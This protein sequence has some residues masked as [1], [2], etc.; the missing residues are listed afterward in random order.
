LPSDGIGPEA[1]TESVQTLEVLAKLPGRF[2]LETQHVDW[3]TERYLRQ[4]VLMS[5]DGLA[6]LEQGGFDGILLGT[7]GEPG[8]RGYSEGDR[9][10]R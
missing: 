6:V 7:V 9:G 8:N 5:K 4:G 3:G 2:S 1:I 10:F